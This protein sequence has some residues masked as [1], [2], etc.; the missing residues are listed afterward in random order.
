MIVLAIHD[1]HDSGVCLLRDGKVIYAFCE[2]RRRNVKNYPGVPEMSI[3]AALKR[4]GTSPKDGD[5]VAISGRLRTNATTGARQPT[6]RLMNAA[7]KLARGDWVTAMG[8]KILARMA[9]RQGLYEYLAKVGPGDKPVRCYAH[10]Q[11]HAATAYYH[12]PWPE[13]SLVL[14]LDGAGD[15]LCATVSVGR[16]NEMKVVSSTP[17]YHSVP[18]YLYSLI[19]WHMGLKPYEHE[20]KVMGMAPYGQAEYVA[21]LLR[22]LFSV[23]GMKFCNHTGRVGDNL[24]PF[25]EKLLARQR[26]DNISAGVQLVFEEMMVKWVKN[27]VAA[28]GQRKIAC[29]GGAFLNVK[30]NKLIRELPEVESFYAFPASD[31]GGTPVGAAI[32]GYLELCSEKGVSPTLQPSRHMYLGLDYTEPEME[33]AIKASGLPYERLDNPAPRLAQMLADE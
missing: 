33:T 30:A 26:F 11:C 19:T 1:G 9:K 13:E 21:P 16:G 14:T 18:A 28:T 27:C 12:R 5:L 23:E 6:W 8:Q 10:H 24:M 32:L 29:A 25:Y 31:D 22:P 3:E 7:Y 4:S 2:E 20:Y 15:G 17:K